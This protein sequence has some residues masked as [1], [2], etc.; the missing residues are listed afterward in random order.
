MIKQMFL[1][2]LILAL[3]SSSYSQNKNSND[4]ENSKKDNEIINIARSVIG[5]PKEELKSFHIKIKRTFSTQRNAP[6]D[7]LPPN[8]LTEVNVIVPDKF[9]SILSI[10]TLFPSKTIS[11]WNADKFKKTVEFEAMG[12]TIIRDATN[13]DKNKESLEFFDGKIDREK[14]D[15]LKK[16]KA[17]DPKESLYNQIWIVLFPLILSNPF[18]P[19]LAFEYV[20]KAQAA[21]QIAN[22]IDVKPKN[23]KNY[24]LLFDSQTNY[25]L[26][27]IENYKED[28]GDYEVKYYYSNREKVDNVLIP[29]KIKVENKFTSQGKEAKITYTNID[30]LEF[31]LNPELKEKM[32]AVD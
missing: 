8:T 22:V 21:D 2:T 10:E 3:T 12:E 29:K 6:G 14:M 5:I 24:R 28:D 30:I 32:F 4:M 27:M 11:L 19:N 1:V 9:Q 26:M 13:T 18:E 16:A 7:N 25:L 31:K 20:G 23:G 15:M 17:K